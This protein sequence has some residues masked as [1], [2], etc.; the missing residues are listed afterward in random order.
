MKMSDDDI[1]N[2][3]LLAALIPILTGIT[4][5]MATK[6][7]IDRLDRRIDG[8]GVRVGGLESQVGDLNR[9]FSTM[10]NGLAQAAG[11]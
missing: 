4:D 8:L 1:T 10:R 9:Q 7:D 3:E 11:R 5:N 6:D 2:K